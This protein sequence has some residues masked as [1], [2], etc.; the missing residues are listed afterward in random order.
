MIGAMLGQAPGLNLNEAEADDYIQQIAITLLS[1]VFQLCW[2]VEF[3]SSCLFYSL[4]A[5]QIQ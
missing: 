3:P 5:A 1:G 2:N 4:Q